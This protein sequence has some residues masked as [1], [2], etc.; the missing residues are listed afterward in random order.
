VSEENI[1]G[2]RKGGETIFFHMQSSKYYKKMW[3]SKNVMREKRLREKKKR[4][5]DFFVSLQ[6]SKDYD[7]IPIT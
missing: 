2:K 4:R 6:S 7:M 3:S 5:S 1:K